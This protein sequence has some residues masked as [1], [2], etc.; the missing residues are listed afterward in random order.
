[1]YN[2]RD[3]L[4][5]H[6]ERVRLKCDRAHPYSGAIEICW[7]DGDQAFSSVAEVVDFK[8]EDMIHVDMGARFR[9]S[10]QDLSSRHSW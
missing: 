9:T 3:E 4:L 8:S 7:P 1:M 2:L 6:D 10:V 5:E